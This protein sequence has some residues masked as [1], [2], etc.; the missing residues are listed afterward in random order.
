MQYSAPDGAVIVAGFSESFWTGAIDQADVYEL[1]AQV[2][3][4]VAG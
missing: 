2:R 4:A 1:L 3:A